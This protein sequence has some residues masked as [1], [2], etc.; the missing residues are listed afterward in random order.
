MLANTLL[1]AM[2]FSGFNRMLLPVNQISWL[3]D[4]SAHSAPVSRQAWINEVEARVHNFIQI[5]VFCPPEPRLDAFVYKNAGKVDCV[6]FMTYF[7]VLRP[8]F[9]STW[10]F[11]VNQS[12]FVPAFTARENNGSEKETPSL[13]LGICEFTKVI[14]RSIKSLKLIGSWF[15]ERPANFYSV[16]SR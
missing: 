12:N 9:C 11:Y 14:F 13:A 5:T 16:L 4:L 6:F 2:F 3:I 8:P 7:I 10:F 1:S 15:P